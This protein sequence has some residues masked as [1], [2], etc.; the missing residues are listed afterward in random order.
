MHEQLFA[1]A[2]YRQLWVRV[3]FV[4]AQ[5]PTCWLCSSLE[6]CSSTNQKLSTY[7]RSG[8][9]CSAG[10]QNPNAPAGFR[11]G[12]PALTRLPMKLWLF[13][14]TVIASIGWTATNPRDS[15]N[16][17]GRRRFVTLARSALCDPPIRLYHQWRSSSVSGDAPVGRSR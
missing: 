11:Y 14:V 17:T 12:R 16:F 10:L 1:K 15:I 5:L 8:D 3:H 4:C 6:D 2:M 9:R 13:S 7:A